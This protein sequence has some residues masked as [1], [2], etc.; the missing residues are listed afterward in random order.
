MTIAA[1]PYRIFNASLARKTMISPHLCRLTFTDPSIATMR[2]LAPDQRI[3][4]FFPSDDGVPSALPD[5]ADWYDVYRSVPAKQRPP[6]RTYTIRHLRADAH[7]VDVDFVLHGETG[8]ASRWAIRSQ[9]GDKVQITAPNGLYEGEIGG[10]EWK[11]PA[12]ADDIL[13]IADET[14]IPAAVG[15]LEQ[16]AARENPPKVQAFLEVPS[17]DD[18]LP[19]PVW[20]GLKVEW[21]ARE[22]DTGCKDNGLL[23][24]EA[25]RRAR[26]PASAKAETTERLSDVN[27]DE[28]V[29]WDVADEKA[30]SFYAWVAGETAA[31]ANIRNFLIKE[32]GIDRH[33]LNLMGYWRCGK[34][35]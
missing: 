23:M 2:T 16:L 18:A 34:V 22:D 25:A 20:D 15:I 14:A 32:K 21:L 12:Q 24:A 7:E 31:V 17:V 35:Y 13:V 1:R 6:M 30:G 8:P 33:A 27:V 28:D 29:L 26:L 5:T 19:L 10:Y 9:I 11:P 3:K 4:I